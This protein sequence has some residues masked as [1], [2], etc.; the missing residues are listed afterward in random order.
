MIMYIA[1]AV[2]LLML[3]DIGALI[4]SVLIELLRLRVA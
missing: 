4:Y 2:T 1:L 3:L